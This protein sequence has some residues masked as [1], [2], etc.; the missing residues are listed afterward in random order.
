MVYSYTS[1]QLDINN[2]K[3]QS[4]YVFIIN[5]GVV[6]WKSSKYKTTTDFITEAKYFFASKAIKKVI[7]IKKSIT[8]IIPNIIDP[9]ALYCN[10]NKALH[11]QKK[12]KVSSTIKTC[13]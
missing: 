7:Y 3:S 6:S 8:V 2:S 9:V 12:I 5:N 1:F 4:R 10:N 11:K 13:T